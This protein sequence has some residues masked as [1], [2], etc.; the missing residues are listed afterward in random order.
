MAKRLRAE[1]IDLSDYYNKD[2]AG[3][4]IVA[5]SNIDISIVES[6]LVI[7]STGGGGSGVP[8]LGQG[9]IIIGGASANE[10]RV[11]QPKDIS[12]TAA[13]RVPASA[14]DS[15]WISD[16]IAAQSAPGANTIV[17]RDAN[18]KFTVPTATNANEPVTLSQM[19]TAIETGVSDEL[20]ALTSDLASIPGYNAGVKQYLIHNEFQVLSWEDEV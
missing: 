6:T 13:N 3:L 15:A 19:N 8:T 10:N 1:Q 5:G 20:D 9:Q 7:S 12:V 11:I 17:S 4:T 2:E 16:G 18:S 14:S